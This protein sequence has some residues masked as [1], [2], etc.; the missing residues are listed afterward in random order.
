MVH[1]SA[2]KSAS[3]SAPIAGRATFTTVASMPAN[4]EPRI[5]ASRTQRPFADPN[6][7]AYSAVAAGTG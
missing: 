7:I 4:P 5:E 3:R 1:C 6:W 2:E